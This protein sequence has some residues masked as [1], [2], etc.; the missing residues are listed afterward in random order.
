[1]A[2]MPSSTSSFR[3]LCLSTK[4]EIEDE[5]RYTEVNPVTLESTQSNPERGD[6]SSV[7]FERSA[8]LSEPSTLI[9]VS[10]GDNV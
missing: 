10:T 8:T 3:M 5:S 6:D 4:A 1:M 9:E 7:G 2:K